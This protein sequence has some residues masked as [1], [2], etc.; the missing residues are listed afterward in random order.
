MDADTMPRLLMA[1]ASYGYLALFLAL[2][3]EELGVPLPVPGDLLLLF[4]GYL[5][6]RGAMRIDL[7]VLVGVVAAFGG[8]SLLYLATRRGQRSAWSRLWPRW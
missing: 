8:A 7:A 4:A 5:V 1:I 2:F 3:L 6:G